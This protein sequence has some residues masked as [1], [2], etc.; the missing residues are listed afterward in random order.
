MALY[1]N[2]SCPVCGKQFQ[3][4]DDIV[5]CPECGTPHHRACYRELGH[6]AHQALHGDGYTF[7]PAD[8]PAEQNQARLP[9]I[10]T[11]LPRSKKK[12]V[13]CNAELDGDAVFAPTAALDNRVPAKSIARRSCR[14]R[15]RIPV[16]TRAP[17]RVKRPPMWQR[18]Y[19][20]TPATSFP[21]SDG[22]KGR[23]ELG[24]LS[25]WPLLPVLPQNV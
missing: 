21:G 20:P 19:A 13:A 15:H 2:N 18:W 3:P 14:I 1:E 9:T 11:P 17:S 10:P 8:P 4:G 6:C 23:M 16:N 12:C 5:T 25:L 22:I 24:G 7:T